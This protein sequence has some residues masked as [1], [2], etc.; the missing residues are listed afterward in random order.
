MKITPG[1]TF[2]SQLWDGNPL[3][4]VYGMPKKKS[5]KPL[6]YFAGTVDE[7]IHN[8]NAFIVG[9]RVKILPSSKSFF[10]RSKRKSD[11]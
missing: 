10:A 3:W 7:A 8:K 2:R 9:D 4:K 5:K 11:K 6:S 1:L